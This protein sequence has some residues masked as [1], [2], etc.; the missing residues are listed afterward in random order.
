M[1]SLQLRVTIE[2]LL[3]KVQAEDAYAG[4]GNRKDSDPYR[5]K[6]VRSI[7]RARS[8]SMRDFF[9]NGY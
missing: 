2:E 3:M 8:L 4:R 9:R 5:T 1:G 7:K 6:V